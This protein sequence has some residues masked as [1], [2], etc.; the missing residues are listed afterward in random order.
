VYLIYF[1]PLAT[2]NQ[3]CRVQPQ[4]RR[5]RKKSESRKESSSSS[6]EAICLDTKEQ[7]AVAYAESRERYVKHPV[8]W[9]N[10]FFAN[11]PQS[12]IHDQNY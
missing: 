7:R 10:S 1:F 12:F 4:Q 3:L 2:I 8:H 5:L 11:K 6:G 9:T